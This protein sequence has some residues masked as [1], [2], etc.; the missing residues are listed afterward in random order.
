M[1]HDSQKLLKNAAELIQMADK[2][3]WNF[4]CGPDSTLTW[5]TRALDKCNMQRIW[6]YFSRTTSQERKSIITSIVRHITED[7]LCRMTKLDEMD[8]HA[9]SHDRINLTHLVSQ[10]STRYDITKSQLISEDCELT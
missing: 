6:D 10:L 7:E 1:S 3:D 9:T 5:R 4:P 2:L 8:L